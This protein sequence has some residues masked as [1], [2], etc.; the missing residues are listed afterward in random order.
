[1]PGKPVLVGGLPVVTLRSSG[2]D[3]VVRADIAPGRGMML[4]AAVGQ[5]A[6]SAPVDLIEAPSLTEISERLDGGPDDFAGNAAFSFGGAI[7]LPYANRIRGADIPGRRAILADLGTARVA[8]PRNWGGKAPSAAQYAMHGLML[9][10]AIP[11]VV[12]T[13]PDRVRGRVRGWDFAGRWPSRI[14]LD[15]E[16]RLADRML[17]L[18]VA[19]TNTGPSVLPIGIGWHP[20]F[21]VPS[22]R[23]GQARLHLPAYA[24]LVVGDYD[25]VLPTGEI[26]P[27]VGTSY[28]FTDP[29][30]R[31]LGDLY[32]DD[33]FVALAPDPAP[34]LTLRVLDPAA[35]CEIRL[36]SSTSEIRAVQVYAPPDRPIVVVEPQFNLTDPFWPGWPAGVDT[37]MVALTPGEAVT[38]QVKVAFLAWAG[39]WEGSLHASQ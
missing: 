2:P 14:D 13:A 33:S 15:L 34:L 28:D 3:G 21:R 10:L 16:W 38:Y 7:L 6:G 29:A 39:R 18:T 27:V 23:R 30:G 9:D 11:D 36:T 5:L 8:L 1:M 20:Y 19:A 22:G 4:L 35:G 37:G 31:A 17:E 12:Q 32:L 26:A 25:T 24:R